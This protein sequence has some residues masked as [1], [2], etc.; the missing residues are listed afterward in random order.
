[1]L[2]FLISAICGIGGGIFSSQFFKE[3]SLGML[4]NVITGF[5]G[6]IA[7]HTLIVLVVGG[8][9]WVLAIVGGFIGGVIVR[10]AFSIIRQRMSSDS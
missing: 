6:G 3:Y 9:G 1:M 8:T 7:T 10:V 4:G 5:L 2:Y